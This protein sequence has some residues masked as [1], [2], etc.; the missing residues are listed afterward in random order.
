VLWRRN[1]KPADQPAPKRPKKP[2]RPL[3]EWLIPTLMLALAFTAKAL[4]P[5]P[6]Q[7]LR[8]YTFD[9]YQR[10]KPR[11]YG[12]EP[13]RIVDLDDESIKRLGQWPWPRTLFAK[14]LERL[15]EAGVASVSFDGFFPE[16]D[17]KSPRQIAS[18]LS[19]QNELRDLVSQLRDLPDNDDLLAATMKQVPT[20]LGFSLNDVPPD[21]PMKPKYG[22]VISG[23]DPKAFMRPSAGYVPNL[24]GLEDA[25]AGIGSINP[26]SDADGTFRR[27]PLVVAADKIYASLMAESLRVATGGTTYIVKTSGGSG[28]I[29]YGQET[30]VV[31]VRLGGSQQNWIVPTDSEGAMWLYFTPE[32]PEQR[33]IPA[34]KVLDGSADPEKLAGNIVFIGT[35]AIGLK[36]IRLTPFGYMPGVVLHAQGVEQILEETYLRRPDF[37]QGAELLALLLFGGFMILLLPRVGAVWGAAVGGAGVAT[38]IGASWFAFAQYGWLVEPLFPAAT[39]SLLYVVSTFLSYFREERQKA[40]IRGAFSRYLSPALVE[41]LAND[42]S[43]LKLG[44]EMRNMTIMFQDIRGFTTISEQFDAVGLTKFINNF[45]TPMTDTVLSNKGTIDKYIGDCIMGLWNAPLDDPNHATNAC[46]CAIAMRDRNYGPLAEKFKAEAEAE[47]RIY[48]P[49]KIGIGLNTGYCCVGNLGSEQRQDYSV[50]GDDVNLASRIE[51]QTKYY[52]VIIAISDKTKQLAPGFAT[53]ELDL[54]TVKGKTEP[55][56]IHTLVGD[57]EFAKK[58]EF[59]AAEKIHDAVIAAYRAQRWDDAEKL[60][61]E[62]SLACDTMGVPMP[63]FYA[64]L[65]ERI[66]EFRANPPPADWDGVFVAT[67]K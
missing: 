28:E 43:K 53:L 33:Y 6:M 10:L 4:D 58:P 13:V 51:G 56:L 30:G 60:C 40:Q 41:Q 61:D 29:N 39:A 11:P 22:M 67:E 25:A 23:P 47:G 45:L 50:L 65:K 3:Y 2:R 26:G 46:R 57:E 36:D 20:V 35:S 21:R 48:I 24:P 5:T 1:K 31:S 16:A 64:L 44:G 12:G 9:N 62:A 19:D 66:E 14:L 15:G 42:P 52:G 38:G 49:I 27:V 17:G 37:A 7:V 63:G 18:A 59:R 34:W 55:V 8:N 32:L 54:L